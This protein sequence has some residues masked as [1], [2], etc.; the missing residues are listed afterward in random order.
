MIPMARYTQVPTGPTSLAT[1][2]GRAKIP[3][4]I[5]APMPIITA[6]KSPIFR[7][8]ETCWSNGFPGFRGGWNLVGD[9]YPPVVILNLRDS[10]RQG[11]GSILG[12]RNEN[13]GW[14]K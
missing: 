5:I 9:S 8:N 3:G 1:S 4:P 7:L 2:P 6:R 10:F 12:G 13:R 11:R 14:W